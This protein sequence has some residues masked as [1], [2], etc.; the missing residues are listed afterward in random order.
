M[1]FTQQIE[2]G[3]CRLLDGTRTRV[4]QNGTAGLEPP[5][6]PQSLASLAI[7]NPTASGRIYATTAPSAMASFVPISVPSMCVVK[8]TP[9][10]QIA[11]VAT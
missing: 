10:K 11:S 3:E 5:V 8:T 4:S 9:P 7:V 1:L 2:C 6:E